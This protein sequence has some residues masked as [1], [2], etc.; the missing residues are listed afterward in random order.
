MTTK[1]ATEHTASMPT[2]SRRLSGGALVG[3]S[4]M[5]ILV[6]DDEPANVALLEGIL[7]G[8]GYTRIT[9]LTDSRRALETYERI[10]PDLVLLDLMMPHLDGLTILEMLRAR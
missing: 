2:P 6:I 1:T 5:K 9:T 8:S 3:H 7:T 10:E 4:K